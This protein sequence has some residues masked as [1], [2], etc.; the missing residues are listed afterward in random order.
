MK[1]V[2]YVSHPNVVIDPNL[3]VPMWRLSEKGVARMQ[4][5]LSHPF[6]HSIETVY[7]SEEQKAI[8]GARIIADHLSVEFTAI[9]E[10][11]ENDRSSTGFLPANEFEAV[12]DQFFASPELSV[13]GW[14]TAMGA[15]KRMLLAI[16]RI[17]ENHSK[18]GNIAI[19]GHGGVG[20]LLLCHLLGCTINR[21]HD[22]PRGSGGNFFSFSAE[23]KRLIHGWL[24]IE[25]KL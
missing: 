16:D 3:P 2:F 7:C 19:V 5:F 22:Q 17:L 9:K 25:P 21:I 8:D 10:L 6:I 1:T 14:E 24:P 13:R 18:D 23:D 12:A 11:G 20:T 4:L 15:Q